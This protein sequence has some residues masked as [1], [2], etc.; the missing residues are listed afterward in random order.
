MRTLFA[1]MMLV[2]AALGAG[3]GKSKAVAAVTEAADAVC[4]CKD[5]KCVQDAMKKLSEAGD[6]SD[7]KDISADDAKAIGEQTQRMTDCA[8]KA[9]GQ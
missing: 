1:A 4:A 3:C 6:K 5:A 7:M 8:K 2:G 9:A